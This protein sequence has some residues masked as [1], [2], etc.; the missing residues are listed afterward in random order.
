M[1]IYF[2]PIGNYSQKLVLLF[3][4]KARIQLLYNIWK[5]VRKWSSEYIIILFYFP[6]DFSGV[7]HFKI[8]FSAGLYCTQ[9]SEW[10]SWIDPSYNYKNLNN[11]INLSL[12]LLLKLH[13]NI[14]LIFK[15][16]FTLRY[17]EFS[18]LY[19]IFNLNVKIQ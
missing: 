15:C 8:Y 4:C 18:K 9:H 16:N 14:S 3:F 7:V 1:S 6:I 19:K 13:C 5:V 2:L 12:L 11:N 17:T 10:A